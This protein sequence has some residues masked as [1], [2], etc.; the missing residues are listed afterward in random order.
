MP[1]IIETK[2]II[3]SLFSSKRMQETIK[4]DI[5]LM[6]LSKY[7]WKSAEGLYFS[8]SA[9]LKVL[10]VPALPPVP[11]LAMYAA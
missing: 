5:T 3:A 9:N 7:L 1:K 8:T 2:I 6:D 4:I 10:L 11:T